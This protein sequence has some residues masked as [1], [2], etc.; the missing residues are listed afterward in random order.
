MGGHRGVDG[1]EGVCLELGHG[2]V[3]GV[4]RRVPALLL[5]DPPG[6]ATRHPIPEEPHLHLRQALVA[7]ERHG[8]ADLIPTH[9]GEQ[10]T[11]GLAS[12]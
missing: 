7:L 5:G 4:E 1:D 6:G 11:E 12:G 2:E 10:E 3:L 9:A 8:L